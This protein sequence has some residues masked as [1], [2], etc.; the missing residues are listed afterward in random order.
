MKNLVSHL[1]TVQEELS[2]PRGTP[3]GVFSLAAL[4]VWIGSFMFREH[5]TEWG[6]SRGQAFRTFSALL[7]RCPLL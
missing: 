7:G 4:C 6:H 3:P 1:R 2:S 5:L